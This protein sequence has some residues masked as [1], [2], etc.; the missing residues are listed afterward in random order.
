M[1][2]V[3]LQSG[4]GDATTGGHG[5]EDGRKIAQGAG[6][7]ASAARDAI[8]GL[9]R[10]GEIAADGRLPPERALCARFAISRRALRRALDALEAEGLIWR[11]QG[12][13]TFAGTPP[14][15]GLDLA[16]RIAPDTDPLSVMEARLA[17]EP[18]LAALAARRASAEDVSRLRVLAERAGQA[19]DADAAE[20]WD[21]ALHRRIAEIAANP[22]LR[23]GFTL[24][25]AVRAQQR[26]QH[27]RQLARSP[28]LVAEYARQHAGIIDAI[29][30]RD[31]GA[32]RAAM[33]AHLTTLKSNL[34]R[35]RGLATQDGPQPTPIDPQ[36]ERTQP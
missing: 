29:H 5:V 7:N 1:E 10:G 34:E 22:I 2:L 6:D 21:G 16:A 25:N 4:A 17:L 12:K 27:E 33:Q 31:E 35:V 32:A 3:T 24:I 36:M 23:A 18:E 19:G 8:F 9:I 26:W 30:A 14:D 28:A 11:H 13:G 20:L 15:P